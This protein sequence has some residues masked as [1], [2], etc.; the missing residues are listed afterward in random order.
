M[1]KKLLIEMNKVDPDLIVDLELNT[2]HIMSLDLDETFNVTLID[3][4]H[5][6]GAVMY[7]FEGLKHSL[8]ILLVVK[9]NYKSVILCYFQV[10]WGYSG[11][12]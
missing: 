7:L 6:P 1:T 3:A 12:R 9:V 5:C 11:D 4:N 8:M 10:F 2:S